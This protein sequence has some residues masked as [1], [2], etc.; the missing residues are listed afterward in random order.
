[1][2]SPGLLAGPAAPALSP[3]LCPAKPGGLESLRKVPWEGVTRSRFLTRIS[4]KIERFPCRHSSYEAGSF[5]QSTLSTLSEDPRPVQ[6]WPTRTPSS[7]Q[8]D[9]RGFLWPERPGPPTGTPG[10]SRRPSSVSAAGTEKSKPG[11][12]RM[13]APFRASRLPSAVC[14][15]R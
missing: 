11:S 3:P 15:R 6:T 1:M 8:P 13:T 4:G 9:H 5:S 14:H 12:T 2:I 7:A 10:N